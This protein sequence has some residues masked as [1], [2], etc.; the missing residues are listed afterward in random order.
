MI[1]LE[2]T[3]EYTDIFHYPRHSE[4]IIVTAVSTSKTIARYFVQDCLVQ[5][6]VVAQVIS[7]E[8]LLPHYLRFLDIVCFA[9]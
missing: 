4:P 1:E 7:D 6:R 2:S 3:C 5:L 9:C 8:L